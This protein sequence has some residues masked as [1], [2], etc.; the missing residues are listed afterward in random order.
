MPGRST[1][2]PR[3]NGGK[4]MPKPFSV[5]SGDR[6][7]KWVILGGLE[8]K[9]NRTY[10]LCR[11]DCGTEKLVSIQHM[12]TG[13]SVSCG[14]YRKETHTIH[15]RSDSKLYQ[16]WA[17]MKTRCQNPGNTFYARYGGRGIIVCDEWQEFEPFMEWAVTNGYDEA[18]TIERIDNDGNYEPENCK[19]I[20]QSEQ[21]QNRRSCRYITYKGITKNLTQ[22]AKETGIN[23]VTLGYRLSAGW[24]TEK[25]LNT[26][27]QRV[28]R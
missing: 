3:R 7:G 14:C 6:F 5:K 28:A 10:A 4:D 16:A 24:S 26:P 2:L 18:L 9:N 1:R 12:K 19:W 21:C 27:S 17:D 13:A 22:W 25:A 23:C 8:R 20:T 15:G 11:C